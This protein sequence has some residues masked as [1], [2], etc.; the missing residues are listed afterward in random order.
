MTA[1][2]KERT[3]R[4]SKLF[5]LAALT[6]AAAYA[7]GVFTFDSGGGDRPEGYGAWLITVNTAGN[8]AVCHIVR[9]IKYDCGTFSLD[10]RENEKLWKMIDRAGFGTM[11]SSTRAGEP[12]E[13]KYTFTVSDGAAFR[14]VEIW[15]SD[16]LKDKPT[17]ALV[18]YIGELIA[19]STLT[20]PVLR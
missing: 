11:P 14:K 20:P 19:E 4:L 12:D 5:I 15:K 6:A 17:A 16:A 13:V 2:G 7:E 18:D 3:M 8:F 1:A 9:A 10:Q